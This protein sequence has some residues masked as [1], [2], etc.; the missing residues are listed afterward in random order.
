MQNVD[1]V[2]NYL[3]LLMEKGENDFNDSN[4]NV[5]CQNDEK[6]EAPGNFCLSNCH[7]CL[8]KFRSENKS[9]I[10]STIYLVVFGLLVAYFV[11]ATYYFID[12]SGEYFR[13]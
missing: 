13:N 12:V 6:T 8:G 10:T 9:I 4:Q 2:L 1:F 7:G 3:L 11:W 5:N